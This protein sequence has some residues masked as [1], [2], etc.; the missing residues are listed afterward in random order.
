MGIKHVKT[1]THNYYYINYISI[2]SNYRYSFVENISIKITLRVT[3]N[4]LLL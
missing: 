3:N 1:V 2:N 4:V